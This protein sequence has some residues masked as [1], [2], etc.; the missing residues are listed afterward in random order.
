MQDV[1]AITQMI[2][3]EGAD[4]ANA[5]QVRDMVF[6]RMFR[7]MCAANSCGNYGKCYMCPPDV[8][9]I[10]E[11]M[12]EAR[13]YDRGVLYQT[14]SPLEDSFDIEGINE[15]GRRHSALSQRISERLGGKK[16][17]LH[18]SSGGCRVCEVCAKREDK[19]CTFP[20]QAIA[21][22]EAYGVNVYEASKTAGMKYINGAN[23][24]TFFGM[25]FIRDEA[26]A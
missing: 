4:N 24:V 6:D 3:T 7:D 14:I 5:I 19:P 15:A 9:G 26:D 18:V 10:D 17:V 8:G 23:T 20:D 11:M 22:L 12:D 25:V 1:Q 13:E 2:L 16:G 21:S